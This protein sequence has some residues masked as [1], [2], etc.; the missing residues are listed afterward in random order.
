VAAG[1][2]DRTVGGVGGAVAAVLRR[3]AVPSRHAQ[4]RKTGRRSLSNVSFRES[5]VSSG[6]PPERPA[7]FSSGMPTV[8]DP[9]RARVAQPWDVQD[10][11]F[12]NNKRGGYGFRI[13]VAVPP[14]SLQIAGFR[15]CRRMRDSWAEECRAAV[16]YED[17]ARLRCE[18]DASLRLSPRVGTSALPRGHAPTVTRPARL[19]SRQHAG[20]KPQRNGRARPGRR[21]AAPAAALRR[22]DR[23]PRAGR[24]IAA[25]G[26]TEFPR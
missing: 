22:I 1:S 4:V 24:R 11:P 7:G 3:P 12:R 10:G 5:A 16:A 13:P 9:A 21:R 26:A 17:F 2:A 18:L 19:T 25:K 14:K 20:P 6:Q 23:L 15:V 8:T